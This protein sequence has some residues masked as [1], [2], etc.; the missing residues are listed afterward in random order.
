M[1]AGLYLCLHLRDFSAQVLV[2]AHPECRQP[3]AILAGTPPLE[4]VFGLNQRAR[5]QGLG[6]G[7]G[8]VQAE[9]FPGTVV[10]RRDRAREETSFAQLTCYAGRIS[11]RVQVL[12]APEELSSDATFI[13]DIANSERLLGTA[14]Q[15]AD[16]LLKEIRAAG[17]EASIAIS[18]NAYATVLAA[19]GLRGIT[20]IAAGREAQTLSPLPFTVLEPSRDLAQTLTAWGVNTLGQLAAL[21]LKS[22]VARVGQDGYRLH[23]LARGQY[24]HLLVPEA[25]PT[26]VVM[27]ESI[28]LDH[29][30][31][32][33][34]PLLFLISRALEQLTR[35]AAQRALAIASIEICLALDDAEH[36]EHRRMVRP[37]LPEWDHHTL[38]KLIQLDLELHPPRSRIVA[39]TMRVQ[40]ARPQKVQQG[41]FAPQSPEAGNLEV[42]LARL[43]KLVGEEHVGSPVLL[44]TH[45]PDAFQVASFTTSAPNTSRPT[46]SSYRRQTS[47]L[48]MVRPPLAV[49][50]G[51]NCGVPNTVVI[52]GQ[53]FLVQTHSGP[54]HTSGAWWTNSHWCREEWDIVLHELPPRCLRLAFDPAARCWHLIGIYD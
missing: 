14:E 47:A 41:L 27:V 42:L 10:L 21:P 19:R 23:R 34:A 15:I 36:P 25:T 6:L 50:V 30:V 40:P 38:L 18:G 28:E 22:L 52:E 17:Y 11:P 12:A 37:A 32:L 48:R 2:S 16:T 51:M 54:W 45:R 4:Y 49:Q 1:P 39:F 46:A 35:R 29:P 44:D 43:R 20:I 7:M 31:E 8:R 3:L 33:L 26:D 13:L 53:H 9:S 24:D 5:E